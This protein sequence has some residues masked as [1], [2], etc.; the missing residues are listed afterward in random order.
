LI[1]FG[2]GAFYVYHVRRYTMKKFLWLAALLAALALVFTGCGGGTSSG[3]YT[4]SFDK[5]NDGAV[6]GMPSSQSVPDGGKVTKPSSPI[7]EGHYVAAWSEDE[8]GELPWDF[9]SDLVYH[10]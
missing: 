4:V 7:W 6:T 9:D 10:I 5:N 1:G 3:N 2:A 8:D